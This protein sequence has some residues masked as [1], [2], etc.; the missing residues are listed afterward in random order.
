MRFVVA[1]NVQEA[2]RIKFAGRPHHQKLLHEAVKRLNDTISLYTI[3]RVLGAKSGASIDTVEFIAQAL[4]LEL[5]QLFRVPEGFIFPTEDVTPK[6][7]RPQPRVL[8]ERRPGYDINKTGLPLTGSSAAKST[9]SASKRA[10][11]S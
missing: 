7:V 10:R 2:M 5:W 3:Q 1:H 8:H 9:T 11:K 6:K 4:G